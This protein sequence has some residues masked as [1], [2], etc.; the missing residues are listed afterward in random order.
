MSDIGL[1]IPWWGVLL[2]ILW[3]A[4]LPLTVIA[5]ASVVWTVKRRAS[6]AARICAF[7]FGGLWL[8]SAGVNVYV[9]VARGLAR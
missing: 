4:F 2:A 8:L 1:D 5:A 6:R 3:L 9:L 7:G